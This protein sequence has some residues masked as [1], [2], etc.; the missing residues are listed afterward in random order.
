MSVAPEFLQPQFYNIPEA[1][2][3]CRIWCLWVPEP[4]ANGRWQKIPHTGR[5]TSASGYYSPREHLPLFS[6]WQRCSS[7]DFG[8][9]YELNEIKQLWAMKSKIEK[10][11]NTIIGGINVVMP[12]HHIVV[13]LDKCILNGTLTPFA[14]MVV[15]TLDSYTELSPSGTGLHIIVR[16]DTEWGGMI[17]GVGNVNQS[18]PLEVYDSKGVKHWMSITGHIFEGRN[19]IHERTQQIN[20][21]CRE[22][23]PKKSSKVVSH[24]EVDGQP[25]TKN[26]LKE[27]VVAGLARYGDKFELLWMGKWR[28]LKYGSQSEADPAFCNYVASITNKPSEIDGVMRH[29]KLYRS[30]WDRMDYKNKTISWAMNANESYWFKQASECDRATSVCGD[31]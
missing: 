1:L 22:H 11:N 3:R 17:G 15:D 9:H 16:K 24:V 4:T 8:Q 19:T 10:E 25:I 27:I 23:L 5:H 6:K 30:K 21:L 29:S 28:E 13:D 14:R 7:S 18:L 2:T 20:T 31:V 26:R 12:C